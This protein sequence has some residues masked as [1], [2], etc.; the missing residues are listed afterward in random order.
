MRFV[1]PNM[2][3]MSMLPVQLVQPPGAM[4]TRPG[5]LPAGAD[6][7]RAPGR[8]G[9]PAALPGAVPATVCAGMPTRVPAGGVA[10]D[11]AIR[12]A[13]SDIVRRRGAV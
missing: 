9:L 7:C 1:L 6:V 11:A 12:N 10:S 5:V 3:P 4:P 13:R 2:G 8:D